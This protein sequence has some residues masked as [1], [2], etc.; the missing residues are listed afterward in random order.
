LVK[1]KSIRLEPIPV[2]PLKVQSLG[3]VFTILHFI[4]NL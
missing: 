2:E 3:H 1:N 4:W